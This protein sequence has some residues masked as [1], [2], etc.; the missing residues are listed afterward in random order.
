VPAGTVPAG[1]VERMPKNNFAS[2]CGLTWQAVLPDQPGSVERPR[3]GWVELGIFIAAHYSLDLPPVLLLRLAVEGQAGDRREVWLGIARMGQHQQ[4]R[5]RHKSGAVRAKPAKGGRR[6]S[7]HV[8]H[9]TLPPLLCHTLCR[10]FHL[11]PDIRPARAIC[12]HGTIRPRTSA[13]SSLAHRR[14]I[15]DC[16]HS[17][18]GHRVTAC[19][20]S[21]TLTA[22]PGPIPSSAATIRPAGR[23]SLDVTST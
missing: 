21:P 1:Y 4:T 11:S 19:L 7:S 10:P 3:V 13:R 22:R 23:R 14:R 20:P 12:G 17:S 9:P 6:S 5:E 16:D 18:D 15:Q 2:G 8:C